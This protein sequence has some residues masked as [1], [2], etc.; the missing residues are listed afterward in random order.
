MVLLGDLR[1]Q[2]NSGAESYGFE[3]LGAL[4]ASLVWRKAFLE[5]LQQ[6]F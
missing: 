5:F 2:Q 4:L 3:Q 6:I 1:Y